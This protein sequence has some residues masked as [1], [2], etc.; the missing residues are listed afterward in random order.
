MLTTSTPDLDLTEVWLD[1]DSEHKRVRV[2]FPI[3]KWTG[4][5]DTAVVYFEIEP[6]DR[7][8]TH[9]DSAEEVLYIVSGR[10]EAEVGEERAD[11]VAGDLAVIPAMVPHGLV[12]VGE[13]SLKVV[14]FFCESEITSTFQEPI[15][16]IGQAQ[17]NQG[18][19]MAARS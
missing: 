15:Q 14:G 9:T 12:N 10:G 18:A 19:P 16:P 3:N 4:A 6:G 8:A 5:R 7:L 11:V 13:E 17:L 2:T 1:S